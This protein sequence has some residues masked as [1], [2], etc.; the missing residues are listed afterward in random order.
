[1]RAGIVVNVMGST[2]ARAATY[3]LAAECVTAG[4]ELWIMSGGSFMFGDDDSLQA[5]A[6]SV[7]P[8]RY[9][10]KKLLHTLR[11]SEAK[12]RWISIETLDV[13]LLRSN[14]WVQKPWARM[15]AIH[16]AR[17]AA[18]RGVLVLNDPDGLARA[19]TKLYLQSFPS[20]VRPA[21]IITRSSTRLQK[22]LD[23][24]GKII[25]KPLQGSGGAGVFLVQASDRSN[26]G[27]IIESL[28]RD[29]YVVA[30]EFL[31]AS[32]DGDVRL[33]LVEGRPLRVR[34]KY[35]IFR[36]ERSGDD[37]RS[38]L[39]AGGSAAPVEVEPV[40]LELAAAVGPQLVRDGMFLAGLDIIG[41]KLVEI[42][43][44]SPGGLG[45]AQQVQKVNF[46]RAIVDVIE[47]KVALRRANHHGSSLSG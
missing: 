3:R 47:R 26:L 38:N 5:L 41:N 34:G 19:Q 20:A 36:R 31:P 37:L 13:L 33:L 46:A 40:M 1:M 8:G 35:A 7:P 11:G 2:E 24:H 32:V 29:G 21:T 15:S 22:F 17:L 30:Q 27:K 45:S 25:L 23:L 6:R 43:V 39:Y 44:L 10:A 42:N 16:F 28:C 12:Q 9:T 4:H 18:E 14:P